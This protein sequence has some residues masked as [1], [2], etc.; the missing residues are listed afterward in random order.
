MSYNLINGYHGTTL[1]AAL[2]ICQNGFNAYNKKH[3]WLGK[4]VYFFQD[5]TALAWKWA[6]WKANRQN[7]EPAVVSVTI[8]LKDCMDLLDI[9]WKKVIMDGHRHFVEK[10]TQDGIPVPTQEGI[11]E[12]V[13]AILGVDHELDCSVIN[14][15]IELLY[16]EGNMTIRSVRGVF[17]EGR[18]LYKTSHLF[19]RGHVAIAVRDIS[20]IGK[21][22]LLKRP[23]EEK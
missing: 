6:K 5:A 21:P 11:E 4:G 22:F 20:V 2:S 3:Y 18:P 23:D 8:D 7:S 19:T 9:G 16:N 15:T 14:H 1:D 13:G 12:G 10:C 17:W